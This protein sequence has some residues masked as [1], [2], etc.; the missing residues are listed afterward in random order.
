MGAAPGEG[1]GHPGSSVET[2][3]APSAERID[4]APWEF[5][6]QFL[7][8]SFFLIPWTQFT[9]AKRLFCTF[10]SG[11]AG[12]LAN[13]CE[14]NDRV[15]YDA[16]KRPSFGFLPALRLQPVTLPRSN[17]DSSSLGTAG[18]CGEERSRHEG[19]QARSTRI[20]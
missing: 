4:V 17:G 15:S 9:F 16:S 7:F 11:K 12:T 3:A 13:R 20:S 10:P 14:L 18:C 1:A 19:R 8:H 5:G 2:S 6:Q